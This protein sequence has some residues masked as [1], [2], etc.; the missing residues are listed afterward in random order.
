MKKHGNL[1]CVVLI[2]SAVLFLCA[3]TVDVKCAKK[4]ITTWD[5]IW[6]GTY[7][8]TEIKNYT[9]QEPYGRIPIRKGDFRE[10]HLRYYYNIS[11]K[12]YSLDIGDFAIYFKDFTLD[13][14]Y[15]Y[16]VNTHYFEYE[17]IKWRVLK[18]EENRMLLLSDKIID[19]Y[20]M[21][22]SAVYDGFFL[23][24]AGA[25][26]PLNAAEDEIWRESILRRYMNNEMYNLAFSSEEKS[27][28]LDSEVTIGFDY[29]EEKNLFYQDS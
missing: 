14:K 4:N 16:L 26:K 11:K 2:V 20:Y 23:C 17:P 27:V 28:I 24:R 21:Y 8:Q 25:Y 18:K 13:F 22:P 10:Q 15:D 19:Q 7:P 6:F 5:C 9:G 12:I 1:K 3:N 29:N